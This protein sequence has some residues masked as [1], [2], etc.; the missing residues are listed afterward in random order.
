M[1]IGG[2]KL[3]KSNNLPTGVVSA[4]TGENN[5]YNGDF[6]KTVGIVSHKMAVGTVKLL[7]L[8]TESDYGV[9]HQGTLIASKYAMG[10]GILRPEAAVELATP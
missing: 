5:T 1:E 3:Y 6:T 10:T 8:A 7:D 4:V 2:V 9:R